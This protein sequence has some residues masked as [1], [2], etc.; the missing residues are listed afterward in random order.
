VT[1]YTENSKYYKP[2]AIRK[3]EQASS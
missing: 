1:Q 2:E 3:P